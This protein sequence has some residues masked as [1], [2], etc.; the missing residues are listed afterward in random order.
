MTAGRALAA[1]ALLAACAVSRGNAQVAPNAHWRTIDT[2]HFHVHFTPELEQSARR[3]AV[4]A[5]RAYDKLASQ[6]H[7][8]R[9]PIDLVVADNV[10]FANGL[11]TPFP[12]NRIVVYAHPPLDDLSLRY[13]DD[14]MTLVITHELTHAFHL[15]RTRGWW[16]IAQ[17]VFGR[18][19]ALFPNLYEPGWVTEGLAVYFESDL[20]GFGRVDGTYEQMIVASTARAHGL[21]GIDKWSLSTTRYPY[22]DIAYGDGALFM[23]YLART[24]GAASIGKFVETSSGTT[25]P[26]RLNHMARQGF[27]ISYSDAWRA[28]RD[29]VAASAPP[30]RVPMP[31][32]RDVTEGGHFVGYPRWASDGSIYYVASNGKQSP[33][34]ERL[35][36]NG[37]SERLSRRNGVSPNVPMPDGSVVYSQL[38]LVDP[39][40]DRSDLYREKDGQVTRLTHGA[41][42][43]AV[44][45]RAD[46]EMIA[47]QLVPATTVL[48]RVRPDGSSIRVITKASPDTQ[49]AE[50]KWSQH[51]TR[52]VATRWTRGGFT[53]IVILDT[54]GA[55]LETVA[56]DHASSSQAEWALDDAAIVYASDRSGV[57]QLYA[58]MLRGSESDVTIRLTDATTGVFWPAVTRDGASLAAVRWESDGYHLGIAPLDRVLKG[59]TGDFARHTSADTATVP[60]A[61]ESTAAA[62][63]FSPWHSLVPRYW[64][65]LVGQ[66]DFGDYM[67]GAFTSGVDVVGR[68]AYAAQVLIDFVRGQHTG[69]L[70]YAYAGLGQPV[71]SADVN[72]YW[73]TFRAVDSAGQFVGDL[74]RRT[75][76]FDIG[77]TFNR[78][79][80]R[81]NAFL[82]VF[83]TY[84][85]RDY[86][87]DPKPLVNEIVGLENPTRRYWIISSSA[88][89]SNVQQPP[90]SIS[91]EDG[92]SVSATGRLKW[93]DGDGNLASK[94]ISGSLAAYKSIDVGASAHHVIALRAAAGAAEGAE[95]SEFDLGGASGADIAALPG[96]SLGSRRIFAVRGFPVGVESGTRIVA[97]SLEYRLP[98]TRPERGFGLWPVFLDRTSLTA[99]ADAGSASGGFGMPGSIA[100]HWVASAGGEL[101]INLA[102]PYDVPYLLRVGVAAPV[103]N[104]SGLD[105]SGASVYVRLGFSF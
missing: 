103:L 48:A 100:D 81:T 1:L 37:H 84:E 2:R 66:N 46:G 61:I 90:L 77:A 42:L 93:H 47:V 102:V 57:S 79:R 27:G 55:V 35:L 80:V 96:V 11:T 33:A 16:R 52:I 53:E 105:V 34:L 4:S 24:R 40:T 14:W 78:P 98:F 28:W 95:L 92:L 26:F 3:A 8:P 49:W 45:A 50:P 51:G 104:H 89:W 23:D 60:R 43:T 9:G 36:A 65:P 6:L 25:I 63:G 82:S 5:E 58:K 74:F 38:D 18:S 62:H 99:F 29:S 54:L 10:D 41:R 85:Q 20:T 76:D 17:H 70:S 30:E 71:L 69:Q 91:P 67:A 101:G 39:Y 32:W 19:P 56:R 7:E 97:G 44:D 21:L 88:G 94:N 12:T 13:Y 75:R 68:H 72:Q 86:T 15:D 31:G 87:T 64:L 73:D 59:A 83:G 22:G